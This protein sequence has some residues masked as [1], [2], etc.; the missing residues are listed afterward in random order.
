METPRFTTGE[1]FPGGG[2]IRMTGKRRK[3]GI[4]QR[5]RL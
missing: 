5:R 2:K 1:K 3:K 4:I